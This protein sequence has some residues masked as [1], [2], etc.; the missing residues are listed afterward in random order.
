MDTLFS[1]GWVGGKG[2]GVIDLLF[3]VVRTWSIG[4][5]VAPSRA[6][7]DLVFGNPSNGQTTSPTSNCQPLPCEKH[8]P[9]GPFC[10]TVY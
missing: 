3:E 5:V 9:D 4:V 6:F 7:V 10:F 2:L 8:L 1:L